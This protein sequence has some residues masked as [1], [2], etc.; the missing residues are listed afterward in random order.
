MF[1]FLSIVYL[2]IGGIVSYI[3]W[4]LFYDEYYRNSK[5]PESAMI[6]II[7]IFSIICWPYCLYK[8]LTRI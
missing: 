8:I 5:N 3:Y 4:N 7:L 2:I 1:D 6:S